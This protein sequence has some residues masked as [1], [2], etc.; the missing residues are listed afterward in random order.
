MADSILATVQ[1]ELAD[2][3]IPWPD[4]YVEELSPQAALLLLRQQAMATAKVLAGATLALDEDPD[5]E[6]G[7]LAEV[8][9]GVAACVAGATHALV[10]LGVLPEEAETALEQ[11]SES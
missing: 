9:N 4:D 1:G 6:A 8:L 2:A 10:A 11:A 3:L 7:A 5:E